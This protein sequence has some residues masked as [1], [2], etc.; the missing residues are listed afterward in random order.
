MDEIKEIKRRISRENW[1][2]GIHKYQKQSGAK[3]EEESSERSND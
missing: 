3:S 1:E 2:K